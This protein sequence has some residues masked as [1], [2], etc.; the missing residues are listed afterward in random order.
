MGVIEVDYK[1]F[2]VS[3]SGKNYRNKRLDS[4]R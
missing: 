1:C 4:L 2:F 3:K